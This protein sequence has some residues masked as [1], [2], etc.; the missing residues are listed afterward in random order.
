MIGVTTT[1]QEWQFIEKASLFSITFWNSE[2]PIRKYCSSHIKDNKHNENTSISTKIMNRN[3][4]K[5]Q[6][7]LV[8]SMIQNLQLSVASGFNK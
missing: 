5:I 8:L 3:I 2:Q 1:I 6:N 7:W 4:H